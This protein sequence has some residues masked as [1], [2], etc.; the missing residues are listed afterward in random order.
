MQQL[1][2]NHMLWA[3]VWYSA[4]SIIG[5]S[6]IQHL[7]Y[8]GT[9]RLTQCINIMHAKN[10]GSVSI[11]FGGVMIIGRIAKVLGVLIFQT[12]TAYMYILA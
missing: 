8:P 7:D 2:A 11:N 9:P 4:T 12:L 1:H 5:T 10:L 6:S 3:D